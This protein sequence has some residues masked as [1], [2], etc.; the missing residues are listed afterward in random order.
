[1][2]AAK[3]PHCL[4]RLANRPAVRAGIG[5]KS[6][7]KMG[8][9]VLTGAAALGVAVLLAGHAEAGS[10]RTEGKASWY[11]MGT[12]TANGERYDPMGITAAH[13]SLPFNTKVRV[14]NPRSGESVVV[15]INDRGP[16]TGGR[17]IDLSQ[18]AA[19]AID[20]VK[21]GVA[22]VKIEVLGAAA[23][24]APAP[25]PNPAP[26]PVVLASADIDE[27]VRESRPLLLRAEQ[28]IGSSSR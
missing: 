27:P 22:Q 17:I 7:D 10:I 2:P 18:G 19:Q 11:K 25:A 14:T 15:R 6:G 4:E 21:L 26:A 28:R 3:R 16:F 5:V 1:M 23:D 13:P 20:L 24:A 12:R 8:W 9:R